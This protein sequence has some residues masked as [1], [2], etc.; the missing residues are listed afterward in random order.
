MEVP[1]SEMVLCLGLVFH[2]I[3]SSIHSLLILPPFLSI[4]GRLSH[5]LISSP[6]HFPALIVSVSV[7]PL[8][9]LFL[10]SFVQSLSLWLLLLLFLD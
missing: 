9:L 8:S 6:L 4:H 10:S 1:S 3:S 5:H 2:C 7:F